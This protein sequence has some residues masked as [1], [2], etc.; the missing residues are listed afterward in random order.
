VFRYTGATAA[1]PKSLTTETVDLAWCRLGACQTT[2]AGLCHSD[3]SIT[4]SDPLC[5]WAGRLGTRPG[6]RFW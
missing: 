1:M 5:L 4:T 3:P 2:A 6:V